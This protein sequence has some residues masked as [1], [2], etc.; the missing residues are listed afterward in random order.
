MAGRKRIKIDWKK[1]DNALIAGANGVQVAALFGIH[2]DTLYIRCKEVHKM[3]FSAYLSEK[4][5]KGNSLLLAKQYD[6]AMKGDRGM[7]IWLG[8][9]RLG[10]SEN[11]NAEGDK[12]KGLTKINIEIVKDRKELNEE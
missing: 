3:D 12:E 11:R 5:E 10:Q 2:P 1:V 9:N 7:L 4:R 6:L 8:K